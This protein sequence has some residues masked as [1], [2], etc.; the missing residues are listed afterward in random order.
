MDEQ[1]AREIGAN[2]ASEILK[3]RCEDQFYSYAELLED[4]AVAI[5]TLGTIEHGEKPEKTLRDT[6][7]VLN[8]VEERLRSGTHY[9]GVWTTG[10]ADTIQNLKKHIGEEFEDNKRAAVNLLAADE[11]HN[12]VHDEGVIRNMMFDFA[13]C[14]CGTKLHT[15]VSKYTKDKSSSGII[16]SPEQVEKEMLD[17]GMISPPSQKIYDLIEAIKDKDPK[18]TIDFNKLKEMES[19]PGVKRFSLAEIAYLEKLARAY[20]KLNGQQ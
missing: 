10:F 7:I 12:L 9:E 17:N 14:Q 8:N 15:E 19:S 5:K 6:E 16:M 2:K 18:V 4:V 20:G 3:V 1:Q 13:E 11:L